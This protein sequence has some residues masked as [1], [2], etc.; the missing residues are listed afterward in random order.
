MAVLLS[1]SRHIHDTTR[2]VSISIENHGGKQGRMAQGDR[3]ETLDWNPEQ[4][5]R[6]KETTDYTNSRRGKKKIG[7]I[8][9]TN[10]K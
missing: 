10:H 8:Y 6:R 1:K 7:T 9:L 4:E 3:L 2:G 5:P